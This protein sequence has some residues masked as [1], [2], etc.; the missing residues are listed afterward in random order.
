MVDAGYDGYLAVEGAQKGDAVSQDRRSLE[1]V[2]GLIAELERD[3]P[4]GRVA[5]VEPSSLAR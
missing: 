2:R 1:Y 5:T 3:T 4:N